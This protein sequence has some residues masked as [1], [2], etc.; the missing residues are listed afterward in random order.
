MSCSGTELNT[1]TF[2]FAKPGETVV[3]V[4]TNGEDPASLV[5]FS[6]ER[7]NHEQAEVVFRSGCDIGPSP[8]TPCTH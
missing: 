6:I 8:D 3:E 7:L 4:E 5:I 2:L 1:C